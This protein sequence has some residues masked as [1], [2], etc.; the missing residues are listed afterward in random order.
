MLKPIY[1]IPQVSNAPAPTNEPE[2][3]GDKTPAVYH[4]FEPPPS[5]PAAMPPPDA[6]D[7][8]DA[9]EYSPPDDHL[10]PL[11][12]VTPP[13]YGGKGGGYQQPMIPQYQHQMYP[14]NPNRM[15]IQLPPTNPINQQF[16]RRPPAMYPAASSPAFT[17]VPK[18]RPMFQN[19]AFQAPPSPV[20][21]TPMYQRRPPPLTPPPLP[22]PPL[23]PQI[24]PPPPLQ[25]QIRP[26]PLPLPPQVRP[27][28]QSVARLPMYHRRPPPP[29]PLQPHT[30]PMYQSIPRPPVSASRQGQL[31]APRAP[32]TPV[33]YLATRQRPGQRVASMSD[34]IKEN[35]DKS[36]QLTAQ[37]GRPM[38][39]MRL[40]VRPPL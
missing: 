8:E 30:R 35:A 5:E 11:R 3:H 16:R 36:S 26:P 31:F 1:Q 32:M 7:D 15:G 37:R 4:G 9:D 10:I 19:L 33:N 28:Y 38:G 12:N 39:Q 25:P 23:Q 21:L 34:T 24:R 17:S 18:L 29:S 22:P 20:Q 14:S 13:M 6:E 40:P 27:A 2:E